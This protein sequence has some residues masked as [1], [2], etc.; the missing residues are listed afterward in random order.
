MKRGEGSTERSEEEPS[1]ARR[2]PSEAREQT[3]GEFGGAVSPPD[4]VQGQSPRKFVG[5]NGGGSVFVVS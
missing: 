5:W 3:A 4:W 1:E 2:R